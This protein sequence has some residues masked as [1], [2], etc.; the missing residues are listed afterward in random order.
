M[1]KKNII[2]KEYKDMTPEGK[3]KFLEDKNLYLE[4]V[5]EYL[6]K[7]ELWFRQCRINNRRKSSGHCF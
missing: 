3:A 2:I 1:P 5:N 4:A 6:K 7:R